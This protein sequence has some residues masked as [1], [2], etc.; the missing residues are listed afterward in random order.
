MYFYHGLMLLLLLFC[1]GFWRGKE[2]AFSP[3]PGTRLVVL[4]M[5]ATAIKTCPP[6]ITAN[7]RLTTRESPTPL[8]ADRPAALTASFKSSLRSEGL[9]SLQA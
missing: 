5:M 1:I 6:G 9:E 3:C 7:A 4:L 8:R 2:K